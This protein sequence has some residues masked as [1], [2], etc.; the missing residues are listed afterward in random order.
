MHHVL[1]PQRAARLQS[2]VRSGVD[3]VDGALLDADRIADHVLSPS[4]E[5]AVA[6]LGLERA[7]FTA[8]TRIPLPTTYHLDVA[9]FENALRAELTG[10]LTGGAYRLRRSGETVFEGTWAQARRPEDPAGAPALAWTLTGRM[11]VASVSKLVTAIAL[12]RALADRGLSPDAPIAPWL[13]AYWAPG[14][15]IGLLTF[16]HLM[17]HTSGLGRA[18]ESA[19][20][21]PLMRDRVE[22]GTAGVGTAL[23]S[24]LN[25]GL[26]RILVATLTGDVAVGMHVGL[27][28][29]DVLWD[30]A[31]L[32]SYVRFV[33]TR[34][35]APSGVA[36]GGLVH[37]DAHALGYPWPG[38]VPGWASGD[39]RSWSGG[40]GW[41]LSVDEV[42]RVL[43]TLRRG[44]AIL[45]EP[46]VRTMLDRGFGVDGP[47]ATRGGRID[48]KL[49]WWT[50]GTRVQQSL[51]WF[52]P[53]DMELVV[54]ANSGQGA[55]NVH[56]A[57]RVSTIYSECLRPQYHFPTDPVAVPAFV[58]GVEPDGDLLWY[59]HDGAETGGG[60][61]TWRGPARVGVGW[62]SALHV[63]PGGGDVL[64][65]VDAG[66]LLWWYQ[67]R[68]FNTGD[69][70]ERAD[71]WAE[72][73]LVGRGW[74][75]FRTIFSGGD[76]V[77]YAVDA[78]GRLQWYRHH[79]VATGAGLDV[80]GSWS[81]PHEV[82]TGWGTARHLFSAGDGILY[83]V[84]PDGVLRWYR[85]VGHA[86]G[87]GLGS[88]GAWAGPV[89]VGTGWGD[90]TAVFSKGDGI[91]YAVMPDGTLRWF[92]HEGFRTGAVQWQ[93][94]VQ[95]GHGWE[96]LH[97]VLAL[98]PR[99][100][101]PVR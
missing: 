91:I 23:Y 14:P 85:H 96:S 89:D 87:R 26:C 75:G 95:V 72:R 53:E 47:I 94:P 81:G 86:D 98:L 48:Q 31:T 49:G 34:V 22:G 1:D 92:R 36:G 51:A 13:P 70:L 8:P 78:E 24:N 101:S 11:H 68:A 15:N 80:P 84:M 29:D 58:Y 57:G 28:L 25:F 37:Q 55:A 19:S 97:P 41:H 90:V 59:R 18:G 69:G 40:V 42:L 33:E 54:L 88:P 99:Q 79:G 12:V 44:G 20:D 10:T 46:A 38:A 67:H 7:V 39:L 4:L 45:P 50:S 6:D 83:A 52:L 30:S 3:G 9:A 73:R 63:V 61:G 66:G 60:A 77:L 64:Y 74:G 100:P 5:G 82:G 56:L 43:G 93:G 65:V 32:A 76:G 62:G 17:N 27:G 21:L 16:A 2:L 35:F 71:S